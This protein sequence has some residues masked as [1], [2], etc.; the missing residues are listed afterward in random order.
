[1]SDFAFQRGFPAGGEPVIDLEVGGEQRALGSVAKVL[2]R[3]E[4]DLD[5]APF[6]HGRIRAVERAIGLRGTA[7]GDGQSQGCERRNAFESLHG[8]GRNTQIAAGSPDLAR[9][10]TKSRSSS[11]T[12]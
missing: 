4:L 5:L 1:M 8:A 7:P 12:K 9:T 3:P 2:Y 6:H 10:A 11:G